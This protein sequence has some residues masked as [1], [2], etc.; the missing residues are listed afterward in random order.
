[1][2]ERQI[3]DHIAAL[4]DQKDARLIKGIG[5]DCAVVEKDGR[6]VWLLTMDTVIEGVHFDLAFHPPEQLGRKVVSVNV[7]DIGAMGGRPVFALLSVGMPKTFDPAWFQAFARG[8]AAGCREYGCLLI[9]GDTVASP[10]G[11]NCT[12][13]VIGEAMAERVIYRSGARP[14]NTVWVSGALGLA[15]AGLELLRRQL[16]DAGDGFG[17]LLARHLHPT[18]RVELGR[19]LGESGLVHAM[20]D[21]SDGLATD[22]AHLCKQS[23]VGARIAAWDLPIP[24]ALVEAARLVG[25]DPEQWAIGGGEDY[26]LLFTAPAEA[27]DRLLELGRQCGLAITPVGTVVEGEGVILLRRRADGTC[28]ERGIAYQGFDHFRERAGD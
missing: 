3:I 13:T 6:L 26:E 12:L 27:H 1:M 15:A 7:S 17:P 21:L 18:A 25:A 10:Q 23:G 24:P 16:D 9:G 22:L 2:N 8:L 28:E 19:R 5:D 20:M 4:T 11:F 14:G